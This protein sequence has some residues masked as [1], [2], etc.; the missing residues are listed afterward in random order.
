MGELNVP[1]GELSNGPIT[2]RHVP[3]TEG[4]KSATTDLI[5]SFAVVERRDHH[6]G[7]DLV[8]IGAYVMYSKFIM[9]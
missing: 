7:E 1:M 8:I 2:H 4:L 5:T 6:Y 9:C 3:H